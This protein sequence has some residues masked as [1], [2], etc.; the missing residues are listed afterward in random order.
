MK[1]E[2]EAGKIEDLRNPTT[3]EKVKVNM[4]ITAKRPAPRQTLRE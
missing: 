2:L 3:A 4:R 1:I